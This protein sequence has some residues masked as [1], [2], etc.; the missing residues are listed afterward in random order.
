MTDISEPTG[1]PVRLSKEEALAMMRD[2][3]AEQEPTEALPPIIEEDKVRN[4]A[5][6]MWLGSI[7]F[8]TERHRLHTD[9]EL[10]E[11]CRKC[12]NSHSMLFE[13]HIAYIAGWFQAMYHYSPSPILPDGTPFMPL[14]LGNIILTQGNSFPLGYQA[15]HQDYCQKL[16]PS[17][18]QKEALIDLI[19]AI[20]YSGED[21]DN[22]P[23]TDKIYDVGGFVGW[24]LTCVRQSKY[25]GLKENVM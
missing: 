7:F 8:L 18:H 13:Q 19:L 1:Q 23:L 6:G 12:L 17:Q 14:G 5:C 20:K 25:F 24:Y 11:F 2:K 15:G 16:R 21:E 9:I 10:A 22:R 3:M 4:F